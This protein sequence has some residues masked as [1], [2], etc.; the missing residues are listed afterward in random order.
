[1]SKHQGT[2]RQRKARLTIMLPTGETYE[3]KVTGGGSHIGSGSYSDIPIADPEVSS[4]HAMLASN[5]DGYLIVDEGSEGGTFV[6]GE[7]VTKPRKLSHG[8]VIKMGRSQITFTYKHPA[9]ALKAASSNGGSEEKKK[10]KKRKENKHNNRTY[11]Q[12]YSV[13][14][15]RASSNDGEPDGEKKMKKDKQKGKEKVDERIKAAKVRAWGGIIAT[16]L[17]VVLTVVISIVVTRTTGIQPSGSAAFSGAQSSRK[18]AGLSDRNKISGGTYEASGAVAV[19]DA[20]GILFVDDSKPDH[21]FYMPVN[22]LGEQDGLVKAIPLGVSVENPEGISQFGSRFMIT[23]ALSTHESNDQGGVAVFDFDP[24]TQTV[25]RAVVLTGMRKFLFD[26]V[27]ELKA[28]ANK[29]GIEGGLN[30]EGITVDPNPEHPRVLLGLRGPILNGNALVVPLKI[31]DRQAPLSIE[32]LEMDEPNAIQLNLN[33][34][35]I[36]D[37][38]YDSRLRSFLIISGAPETAEK[39]DFTLWEWN[40]EGNQTREASRPREQALLDKKMKP[41]GVTHLKILNQEFVFI[42]GDASIYAKID[43]ISP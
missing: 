41:E 38:Q 15:A 35:A 29:T 30:I 32:N 18:L 36:R 34:Q 25:S 26:N 17:S 33:G 5:G 7:Q 23:G 12:D 3:H 19:P 28:W 2:H 31:R 22:E 14:A 9:T 8:D 42:V 11:E 16:V 10:H 6:N 43:Y 37:I 40:G 39:T 20:N 21:V 1:M 13:A 4:P 27:P 24:A